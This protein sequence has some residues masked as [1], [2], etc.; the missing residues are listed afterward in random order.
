VACPRVKLAST[1][2]VAFSIAC[3]PNA[4]W[5]TI[6]AHE[7]HSGKRPT[8]LQG[9]KVSVPVFGCVPWLPHRDNHF[10]NYVQSL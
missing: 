9:S 2:Q 5:Q 1:L 8:K 4:T 6:H 7:T 3:V 10:T